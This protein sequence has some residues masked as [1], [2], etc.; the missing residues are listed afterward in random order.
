MAQQMDDDFFVHVP[1]NV[2]QKRLYGEFNRQDFFTVQL[3][4]QLQFLHHKY[5]VA[6]VRLILP[7][8]YY[9]VHENNNTFEYRDFRVE[10]ENVEYDVFS[11]PTS[12]TFDPNPP[13]PA[14]S[15]SPSVID[16]RR[17]VDCGRHNSSRCRHVDRIGCGGH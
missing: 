4:K 7:S 6:A 14:S 12:I 11:E 15:A 9:A 17:H 1:S 5:K 16:R 13:A 8:Y 10:Q 2:D 3:P